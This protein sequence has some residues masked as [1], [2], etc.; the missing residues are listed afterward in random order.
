MHL[1][2]IA[3]EATLAIGASNEE[4]VDM[5]TLRA[6]YTPKTAAATSSITQQRILVKVV[7]TGDSEQLNPYQMSRVM[8]R[9]KRGTK[10]LASTR[11]HAQSKMTNPACVPS[12]NHFGT[13]S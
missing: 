4:K 2:G 3:A 6:T 10:E 13:T 7:D 8:N 11:I 9:E 5:P 12:K 1:H